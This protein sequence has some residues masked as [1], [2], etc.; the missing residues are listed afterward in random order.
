MEGTAIAEDV[1]ALIFESC[2]GPRPSLMIALESG[3]SFVCQP[4]SS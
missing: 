4:L 3:I 2:C 1:P